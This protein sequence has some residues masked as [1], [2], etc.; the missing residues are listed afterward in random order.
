MLEQAGI[1]VST[2]SACSSKKSGSHVLAAMGL[3]EAQTEGA[4]RFSL[5]EENTPDQMEYVVDV[6]K[7][8]VASQRRLRKAL[9]KEK[10]V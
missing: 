9:A 8:A 6:L 1:F 7:K 2:G 5:S 3:S 4:I 10:K